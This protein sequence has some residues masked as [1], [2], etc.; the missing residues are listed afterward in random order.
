MVMNHSP[1]GVALP[2]SGYVKRLIRPTGMSVWDAAV[3]CGKLLSG[4]GTSRNMPLA[5]RS[6]VADLQQ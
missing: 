5:P 2:V 6:D 3:L 1:F 4:V